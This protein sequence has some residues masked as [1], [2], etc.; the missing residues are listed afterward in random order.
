MTVC[1]EETQTLFQDHGES[2]KKLLEKLHSELQQIIE[3]KEKLEEK[4]KKEKTKFDL[5]SN[6]I[7]IESCYTYHTRAW[8]EVI[9]P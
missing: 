4:L 5:L 8:G 3:E 9:E 6:E 2:E 1:E 7:Q